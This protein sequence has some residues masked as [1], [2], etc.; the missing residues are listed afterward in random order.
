[1]S[2]PQSNG[3]GSSP[4]RRAP[5]ITIEALAELAEATPE[6]V[7]E[8]AQL[9]LLHARDGRYAPGDVHRVRLVDSFAA[10]GVPAGALARA[11]QQGTISLTY[12][13]ELHQDPG[14]PSDSTY[15]ELLDRLGQRAEDLRRLFG[16]FALAEPDTDNRLSRDDE[17]LLLAVLEALEQNR[18]PDLA[19][20]AVRVL[21]DS[22]RQGSEAAMSVYDEAVQRSARELAGIPAQDLYERFLQPWARFARLVPTLIGWLHARHLSA[23]IDAWSVA[24]TE[25]LLGEAGFVAAREAELP[26]VAFIDLTGFTRLT[27]KRGDRAA[28]ETA[29]ALADLAR[30]T[31][32]QRGGRLVKQLGDGVLL[33]FPAFATGV[34]ATLEVLDHVLPAGLPPGH[35]GIDT[36]PII[37]REG[38]VFG[39][40]V[41][42]ASRIAD[43]AGAGELLASAEL[44]AR[45]PPGIQHEAAGTVSLRGFAGSAAL[46]RIWREPAR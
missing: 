30:K 26:A 28:A 8:L 27:Q 17:R 18:D 40:T 31:A 35:A 10:A 9:G 44:A 23:A 42:R 15:G 21:G 20:R 3:M 16:A 24:E 5:S 25:R 22:A 36:G 34:E 11:S 7:R 19:L 43:V 6:H 39:S 13:H 33:R 12:Y 32:E 14:V 38:D 4:L 37:V 29:A 41:N 2:E 46:M 45:L 1:M